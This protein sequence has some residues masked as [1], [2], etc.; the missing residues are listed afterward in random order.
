MSAE[1][2]FENVTHLIWASGPAILAI[3]LGIAAVFH[4]RWANRQKRHPPLLRH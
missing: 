2:V 4:R 3:G 1:H